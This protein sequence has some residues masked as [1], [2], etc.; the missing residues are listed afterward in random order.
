MV[1]SPTDCVTQPKQSG[2]IRQGVIVRDESSVSIVQGWAGAQKKDG[3]WGKDTS[4]KFQEKLEAFQKEKGLEVNG[5]YDADTAKAMLADPATKDIA[6][7][8]DQMQNKGVLK[9][10]YR[11]ADK[12]VDNAAICKAP[13]AQKQG[14]I[15]KPPRSEALYPETQVTYR[16]IDNQ[17]APR[18]AVPTGRQGEKTDHPHE[19]ERAALL[20]KAF[21]SAV[22][23]ART[24][25]KPGKAVI[26]NGHEVCKIGDLVPDTSAKGAAA[27]KNLAGNAAPQTHR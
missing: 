20:K 23:A 3:M 8:L 11:P 15:D 26:F 2:P 1:T 13:T 7:A 17:Q 16:A 25:C 24:M 27:S 5:K 14:I 21:D 10:V 6:S 22:D 4:R 9:Q 18:Q 19:P 12:A